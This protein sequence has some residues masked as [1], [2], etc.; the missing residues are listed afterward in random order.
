MAKIAGALFRGARGRRRVSGEKSTSQLGGSDVK[1]LYLF[2]STLP[3]KNKLANWEIAT[4]PKSGAIT[5]KQGNYSY[6]GRN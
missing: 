3:M 2:I 4:G 6:I 1:A 5:N